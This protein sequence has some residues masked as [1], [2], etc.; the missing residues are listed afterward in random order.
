MS[1]KDDKRGHSNEVH[2][3]AFDPNG[4]YI[5]SVGH[6]GLLPDRDQT[7]LWDLQSGKCVY[8]YKGHTD[9]VFAVAASFDGQ[10]FYTAG[11]DN[12]IKTWLGRPDITS[13]GREDIKYR[14]L[15]FTQTV[16]FAF[17]IF[18]LCMGICVFVEA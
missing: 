5:C 12:M 18:D 14:V 11:S 2:D 16:I 8:N 9:D 15:M 13:A 1:F 3:F 17:A 10:R 6:K 7:K 4:R